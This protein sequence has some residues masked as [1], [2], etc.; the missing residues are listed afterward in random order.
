MDRRPGQG[1]CGSSAWFAEPRGVADADM[2]V[3]TNAL[4]GTAHHET[5]GSVDAHREQIVG[6]HR[7]AKRDVG[8]AGCEP[9]MP[10]ASRIGATHHP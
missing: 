7:S 6:K 2:T 10:A 1:A 8:P 4:V 9:C 3:D 5:A